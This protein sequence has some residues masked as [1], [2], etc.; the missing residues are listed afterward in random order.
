MLPCASLAPR[1]IFRTMRAADT[2]PE[3]HTVQL[4]IYRRLGATGRARLAGR[5]SEETRQI[6]RAGI[7]SR[8]PGYSDEDVDHAL[9]RILYG[10]DLFRRV[11]PKSPLLT[12]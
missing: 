7:R 4:E 10:D 12:P 1:G 3:S 11:W 6:S 8:H 9:R 5:L 2:T